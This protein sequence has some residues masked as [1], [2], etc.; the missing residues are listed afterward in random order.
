VRALRSGLDVALFTSRSVVTG[1]SALENLKIG[2]HVSAALVQ[3]VRE[4]D[5]H[6][7]FVI[8]KGGI[9]ASDLSTKALDVTTASVPGQILPGVPVWL[10]GERSRFPGLPLVVFPGNVGDPD[11]LARCMHILRGD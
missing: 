4:L 5:V 6:P 10:L 11:S 3:V 1:D 2:Q 8:A 9:T 7:R